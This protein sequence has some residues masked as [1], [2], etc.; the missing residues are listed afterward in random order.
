MVNDEPTGD[1]AALALIDIKEALNDLSHT[2]I[3]QPLDLL[4]ISDNL[5]HFFNVFLT[6]RTLRTW[7]GRAQ[8]S[9]TR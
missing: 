9:L 3:Q 4:D 1:V 8:G 7:V 5:R 2:I 6:E